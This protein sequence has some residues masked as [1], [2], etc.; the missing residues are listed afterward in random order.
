MF[1]TIERD[2]N[3]YLTQC[4]L[5]RL[6]RRRACFLHVNRLGISKGNAIYQERIEQLFSCWKNGLR[7]C[8]SEL[9]SFDLV[10]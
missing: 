7:D 2:L 6:K 4:S 5:K 1:W 8:E 10:A 9:Y 3:N